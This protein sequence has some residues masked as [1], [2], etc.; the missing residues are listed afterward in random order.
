MNWQDIVVLIIVVAAIV[1]FAMR[2]ARSFRNGDSC[3]S[4]RHDKDNNATNSTDTNCH[5]GNACVGCPLHNS[6]H[7]G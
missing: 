7:K 2:M 1:F 4:C 6:C 3:P 5:G